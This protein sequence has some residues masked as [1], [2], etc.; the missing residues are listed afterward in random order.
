MRNRDATVSVAA[1]R[2]YMSLE[3]PAFTVWR[4]RAAPRVPRWLIE[5]EQALTAKLK[6]VQEQLAK[7]ESTGDG[8]NLILSESEILAVIGK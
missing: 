4:G 2:C 7:L 6:E 3:C 5:K 8:A 1:K